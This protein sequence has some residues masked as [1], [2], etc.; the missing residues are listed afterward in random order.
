MDHETSVIARLDGLWAVRHE[1]RSLGSFSARSE[2]LRFAVQSA[3]VSGQNRVP[4]DI[5]GED[6]A[7]TRHL[8]WSCERDSYS[9]S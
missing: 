4:A 5:V 3:H 2:A 7:G 8:L 9:N 1:G 6:E